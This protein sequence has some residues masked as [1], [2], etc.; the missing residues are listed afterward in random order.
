MSSTNVLSDYNL[1]RSTASTVA[2][3]TYSDLSNSLIHPAT[4]D[5][6][7][8]RDLEAIRNSIKNIV[9]TPLRTR[10][11]FPEFGTN[12][13]NLLFENFNF[14]TAVALEEEI[15]T[16]VSRFEPRI[17]NISV[18]ANPNEELNTYNISITFTPYFGG[19]YNLQFT[20][21]RIR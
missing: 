6:V 19:V 3:K 14:I 13:D 12:V 11:F 17:S 21:N 15:L 1:S 18:S 4:G 7:I 10:P 16:G 8:A 9:L 20:L 5:V 2:S